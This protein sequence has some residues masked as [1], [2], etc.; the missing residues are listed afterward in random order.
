MSSTF[1][2]R[3]F[4]FALLA[5]SGFAL[6]SAAQAGQW[7]SEATKLT[8]QDLAILPTFCRE[9]VSLKKS[10]NRDAQAQFNRRYGASNGSMH[11]Y[12]FGLKAMNL[13]Y[14][15]YRDATRRQYFS[16]Q[17][18]GEFNYVL[19]AAEPEFF[20]R[21]DLLIQ[22]GRALTLSRSYEDARESFEEALKLSP[23]SVDAWVSLSDMY[24]Q[25]GK[26]PEA[27]K[28]LEQ[29]IEVTGSEHKKIKVR[30]DDLKKKQPR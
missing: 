9:N 27:I 5:L 24:S 13:A 10:K 28:V 3:S 30:L 12:C 18:V 14:R 1:S 8:E 17:A 11:H 22:R 7:T 26:N 6:A 19:N 16:T 29:A 21:P 15:D 23:K 4:V 2:R 20:L 25:I